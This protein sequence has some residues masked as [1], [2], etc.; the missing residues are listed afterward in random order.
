MRRGVFDAAPHPG[1]LPVKDGER[2]KGVVTA[3]HP[4]A[5]P[6]KDGERGK[7]VVAAPH[8]GALPVKDGERGKGVVVLVAAEGQTQ[9]P[10]PTCGERARVRGGNW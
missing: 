3:P 8:P 10:L 2:E 7:G 9:F 1:P 5:L 6:V 4:G